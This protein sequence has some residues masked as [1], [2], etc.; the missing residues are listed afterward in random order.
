MN[1]LEHAG[2][3]A[4]IWRSYAAFSSRD[5]RERLRGMTAMREC[6]D[7]ARWCHP[8]VL[9]TLSAGALLNPGRFEQTIPAFGEMAI[10][11]LRDMVRSPDISRRILAVQTL[12]HI[13]G[14]NAFS[15][16]VPLLQDNDRNLRALVPAAL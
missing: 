1:L 11:I 13:P 16:L 14:P 7:A 5:E 2:K 3:Q 12:R 6:G 4:V 10:P 15:T 8:I 9:P